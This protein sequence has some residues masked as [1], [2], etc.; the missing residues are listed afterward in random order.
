MSTSDG[1][2]LICDR[3]QE[4]HYLLCCALI[5]MMSR[6]CRMT[7]SLTH[8]L[9]TR[10]TFWWRVFFLFSLSSAVGTCEKEQKTV[11]ERERI[12]FILS[13]NAKPVIFARSFKR[14]NKD[15]TRR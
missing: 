8:S 2:T 12:L 13:R 9:P 11:T 4:R 6:T 1:R 5:I 15:E 7:I 3:L 14:N 10:R